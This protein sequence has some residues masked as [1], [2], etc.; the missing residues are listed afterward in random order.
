MGLNDWPID[1]QLSVAVKAA[2]HPWNPSS[3]GF[4]PAPSV[5]PVSSVPVQPV[6]EICK[7]KM[8][9]RFG[10][11]GLPITEL[12]WV[13]LLR[14]VGECGLHVAYTIQSPSSIQISGNA[15]FGVTY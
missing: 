14:G 2:R 3:F 13:T 9:Q 7:K 12:S 4:P 15:T 10:G 1:R 8:N 5:C 6:G 11:R